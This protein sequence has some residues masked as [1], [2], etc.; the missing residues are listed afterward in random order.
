M[1]FFLAFGKFKTK[2]KTSLDAQYFLAYRI[3]YG[4]RATPTWGTRTE[5]K[6]KYILKMSIT[7]EHKRA[8][9]S[10]NLR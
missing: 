5:T 3:Q 6:T 4:K 10:K 7:Y 1:L 9:H 2:M 8:P